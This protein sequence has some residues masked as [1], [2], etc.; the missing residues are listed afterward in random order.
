MALYDQSGQITIDEDAAKYDMQKMNDA[1]YY[2]QQ[3]AD[4]L[5]NVAQQA[6]ITTGETGDAIAEK[7]RELKKQVNAMIDRLGDAVDFIQKTVVH[8]QLLDRKLGD[9]F[10]QA[11]SVA[12]THQLG[13]DK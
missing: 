3:S 1:I 10:R 6:D 9:E 11:G 12:M 5:D 8:Y 7:A 4:A 13:G 2:L